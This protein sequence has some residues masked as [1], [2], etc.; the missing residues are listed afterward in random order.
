MSTTR[1]LGAD[2]PGVVYH[3]GGSPFDR[4]RGRLTLERLY[5]YPH[6]AAV[7]GEFDCHHIH[8]WAM[9]DD[10]EASDIPWQILDFAVGYIAGSGGVLVLSHKEHVPEQVRRRLLELMRQHAKGRPAEEFRDG[11]FLAMLEACR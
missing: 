9:A 6:H 1:A 8:V 10:A 3:A 4:R 7:L 2:F 5:S 11:K